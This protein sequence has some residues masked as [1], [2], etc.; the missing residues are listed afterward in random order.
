[1][2]VATFA[3]L[4][5]A[6]SSSRHKADNVGDIKVSDVIDTAKEITTTKTNSCKPVLDSCQVELVKKETECRPKKLIKGLKTELSNSL[7]FKSCQDVFERMKKHCSKGCKA[8]VS[9]LVKVDSEPIIDM[10]YFETNSGKELIFHNA[11]KPQN[12][13]CEL[14]ASKVSNLRLECK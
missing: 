1:M 13:T 2:V 4:M 10:S 7:S 5:F 6:N 11:V 8:D 12:L 14:K 9:T 3:R